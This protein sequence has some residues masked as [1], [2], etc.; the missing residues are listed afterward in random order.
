MSNPVGQLLAFGYVLWR[1]DQWLS[2]GDGASTTP[3]GQQIDDKKYV[4]MEARV[5]DLIERLDRAY[6]TID[7]LVNLID[8]K[9]GG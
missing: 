6:T 2:P 5:D 9:H 1:V 3:T 4:E 7:S 8:N